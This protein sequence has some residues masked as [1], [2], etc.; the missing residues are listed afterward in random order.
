MAYISL[1][2]KHKAE[3]LETPV[4]DYGDEHLNIRNVEYKFHET[5]NPSWREANQLAIFSRSRG[6]KLRCSA[7][8]LQLKIRIG[9]EPAGS[10]FQSRRP[11]YQTNP[12]ANGHPG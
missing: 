11:N 6:V 8:Q 2:E 3:T 1:E 9:H 12:S 7:R 4:S 10:G 5:F